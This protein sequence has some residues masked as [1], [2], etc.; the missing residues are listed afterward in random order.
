MSNLSKRFAELHK[1]K[2]DDEDINEFRREYLM[3]GTFKVFPRGISRRTSQLS[4]REDYNI[5]G[6]LQSWLKAGKLM[7]H[8]ARGEMSPIC[9]LTIRENIRL[10]SKYRRVTSVRDEQ[11][12]EESRFNRKSRESEKYAPK[13]KRS[14]AESARQNTS[15][16]A[17]DALASIRR[18]RER[19]RDEDHRQRLSPREP[20]PVF[21]ESGAKSCVPGSRKSGDID[22]RAESPYRSRYRSD[23]SLGERSSSGCSDDSPKKASEGHGRKRNCSPESFRSKKIVPQP[24]LRASKQS[25]PKTKAL[26][27]TRSDPHSHASTTGGTRSDYGQWDPDVT[28]EHILTSPIHSDVKRRREV[29]NIPQIDLTELTPKRGQLL[30]KVLRSASNSRVASA[31]SVAPRLTSTERKPSPKERDPDERSR[32]KKKGSENNKHGDYPKVDP[33]IPGLLVPDPPSARPLTSPQI[34]FGFA[35]SFGQRSFSGK[36]GSKSMAPLKRSR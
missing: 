30:E 2:H 28:N 25:P 17:L 24:S 34:R 32:F 11:I 7:Y 31:K 4:V 10:M 6:D 33:V 19:E 36:G 12:S 27:S 9:D 15:M 35:K 8:S 22:A 21:R 13:A 1:D 16:T 3:G 14:G 29:K 20:R 23:H 26:P 18:Q 5:L